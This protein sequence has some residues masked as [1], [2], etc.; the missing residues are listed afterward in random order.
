MS[1]YAPHSQ[2]FTQTDEKRAL[3]GNLLARGLT[4]TQITAQLRCS[5]TIV[6]RVRD[7]A[8]GAAHGSAGTEAQ[9]HAEPEPL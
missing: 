9:P 2:T 8:Q 6:R 4:M 1:R 7:G 5:P 3:I